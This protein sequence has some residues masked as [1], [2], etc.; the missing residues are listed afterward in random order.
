MPQ[1]VQLRAGRPVFD[2]RQGQEI[3]LFRKECRPA[4]SHPL[5][6]PV[7]TEASL[8]GSKAAGA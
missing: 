3:F 5:S 6:Y 7:A 2:S 4:E 1:S 8:R